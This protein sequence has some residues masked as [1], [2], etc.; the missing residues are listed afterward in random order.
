MSLASGN[1]LHKLIS[2]C[3]CVWPK[4]LQNVPFNLLPL[5]NQLINMLVLNLTNC[6]YILLIMCVKIRTDKEE[7]EKVP[8]VQPNHSIVKEYGTA[9]RSSNEKRRNERRG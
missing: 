3:V 2:V 9:K 8:I 6:H 1:Q 7:Q 5:I 4:K